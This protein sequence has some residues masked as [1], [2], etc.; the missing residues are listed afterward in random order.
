MPPSVNTGEVVIQLRGGLKVL[1]LQKRVIT[2]I[3]FYNRVAVIDCFKVPTTK[4]V[5]DRRL[6][7]TDI[8]VSTHTY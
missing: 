4:P 7:I 5:S 3:R 1:H 6:F 2:A 8:L